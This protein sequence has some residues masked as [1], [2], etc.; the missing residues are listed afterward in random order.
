M[1]LIFLNNDLN[2]ICYLTVSVGQESGSRSDEGSGSDE[3]IVQL[4]TRIG[5]AQGLT[6]AVGS[7]SM[8]SHMAFDRRPWF[9]PGH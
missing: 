3:V 1:W 5:L 8:L 6:K 4:L 2:G 7:V 9:F